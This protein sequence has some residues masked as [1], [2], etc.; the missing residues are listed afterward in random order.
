MF[1]IASC[2]FAGKHMVQNVRE[3]S[4]VRTI[5]A[6]VAGEDDRANSKLFGQCDRSTVGGLTYSTFADAHDDRDGART[7][8]SDIRKIRRDRSEP[9]L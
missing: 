2:S 6:V 9:M 8:G 7:E 4:G 5:A 3:S 1:D